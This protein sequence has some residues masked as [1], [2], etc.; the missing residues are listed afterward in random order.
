[1]Y[2]KQQIFDQVAVAIIAQGRPSVDDYNGCY[3]RAPDG[4]KCAAGHLIP[5]DE[6]DP[7]M[8]NKSAEGV[9][10]GLGCP[11]SPTLNAISKQLG[12]H[13]LNQLQ[14]AHDDAAICCCDDEP[15]LDLFRRHM[16][17]VAEDQDLNTKV[18]DAAAV[19]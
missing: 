8:E 6:Y 3:Y 12:G 5:D 10:E 17:G 11:R 13:F 14:R 16:A 9:A 4:S 2:T 19:L 18:L 1:M 15:F 7:D